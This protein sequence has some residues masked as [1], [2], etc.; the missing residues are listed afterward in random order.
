MTQ[1]IFSGIQ[2]FSHMDNSINLNAKR[3]SRLGKILIENFKSDLN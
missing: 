2:L 3:F 1:T